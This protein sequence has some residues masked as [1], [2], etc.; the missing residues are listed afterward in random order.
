MKSTIQQLIDET[1]KKKFKV[2]FVK[3]GK[4]TELILIKKLPKNWGKV[5]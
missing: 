4:T 5:K 2:Y 3:N 1:K